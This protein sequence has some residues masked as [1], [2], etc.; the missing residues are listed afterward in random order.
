MTP[1]ES[2]QKAIKNFCLLLCGKKR[3][4]ACGVPVIER[5]TRCL[6]IARNIWD[7]GLTE[8]Q[9]ILEERV[10]NGEVPA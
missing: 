8:T 9:K 10:K 6:R 1:D 7:L 2:T 3:E 4:G 5:H